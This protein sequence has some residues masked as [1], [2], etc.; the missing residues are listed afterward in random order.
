MTPDSDKQSEAVV[1]LSTTPDEILAKRIGHVLLEEGL[2]ACV[3]IGQPMLS[4]YLWKG[5]IRGDQETGLTIKT[6]RRVAPA[7]IARLVEL[8]P[9]DVPQATVVPV[10]D[11]YP[12]YLKWVRD[13]TA[14]SN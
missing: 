6:S 4:M 9:Y 13:S 8:H 14:G 5:E 12:P 10:C 11:G 7:A 1:I 3:Q 2:A